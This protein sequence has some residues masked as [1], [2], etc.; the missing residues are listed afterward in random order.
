MTDIGLAITMGVLYLAAQ[1]I[2]WS[3]V[4]LLYGVPYFWV[5]HWLSKYLSAAFSKPELHC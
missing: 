2:G 3:R 1:S 5:H 4:F